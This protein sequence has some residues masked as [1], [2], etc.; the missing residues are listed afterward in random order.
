MCMNQTSVMFRVSI[1]LGWGIFMAG[2]VAVFAQ[3]PV[4]PQGGEFSIL[5][6]L[7]GDQVWPSLS[8]SPTASMIAWQDNV[9]DKHGAGIGGAMLGGGFVAERQ[10][11]ANKTATG[12]QLYPTV[13]LL[14]DDDAIFVWQSGVGATP[15]S[16]CRWQGR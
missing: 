10:F 3:N 14:A 9:V 4:V 13:Q 6:G 1:T 12:D 8:L 15:G 11:T 2:S 5:G 7:P 16:R